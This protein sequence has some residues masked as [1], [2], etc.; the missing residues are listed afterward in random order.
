[1]EHHYCQEIITTLLRV[2]NKHDPAMFI[3]ELSLMSTI[4]DSKCSHLR[5]G[6]VFANYVKE[7]GEN[8]T[9]RIL[10]FDETYRDVQKA[11]NAHMHLGNGFCKHLCG[12]RTWVNWFKF[13]CDI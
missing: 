7:I 6:K 11:G 1:M 5:L 10:A 4:G 12:E 9:S 8:E 3:R 2:N 13:Q